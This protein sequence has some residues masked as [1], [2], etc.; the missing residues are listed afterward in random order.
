M[1]KRDSGVF[2]D[3]LYYLLYPDGIENNW[4]NWA[5]NRIILYYMNKFR[6]E[7]LLDVGCGRGVVT[8]FLKSRGWNVEGIELGNTSPLCEGNF[9]YGKDIFSLPEEKRELFRSVSLFDVIE[10]IDDPV[11]FLAKIRNFF[12]NLKYVYITVPARM[13]LWSRFDDEV[14]HKR[15]YTLK[16]LSEHADLSGYSIV[17]SR[18]FFH[19]L[20][21]PIMLLRSRRSAKMSVPKSPLFLVLHRLVGFFFF[22]EGITLPGKIPGSSIFAV[23]EPKKF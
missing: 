23:F 11:D 10:H 7:P 18:Y 21:L 2:S 9:H 1:D 19:S 20:Y 15:R 4:W 8:C 13:E 14:G 17:F 16:S 5:R 6:Q 12:H 22:V 3:T